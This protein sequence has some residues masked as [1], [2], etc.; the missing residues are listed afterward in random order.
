MKNVKKPYGQ[1]ISLTW[2]CDGFRD[3]ADGSDED[4]DMCHKMKCLNDSEYIFCSKK[5]TCI[6]SK[7]RC[8]NVNNCG[9]WSDEMNEQ[10][11]NKTKGK[12]YM[13]YYF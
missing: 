2:A 12:C 7:Y 11:R 5:A 13:V 3:C 6:S 8:D 1:C 9:D 4:L 10:C